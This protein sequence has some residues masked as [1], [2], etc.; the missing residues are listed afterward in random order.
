MIEI[1]KLSEGDFTGRGVEINAE[2]LCGRVCA[3]DTCI[4]CACRD[5]APNDV[6]AIAGPGAI[7]LVTVCAREEE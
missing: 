1:C 3:E 6:G 4:A 2:D 7:D 5:F